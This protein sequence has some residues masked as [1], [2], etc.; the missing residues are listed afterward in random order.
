ML[1]QDRHIWSGVALHLCGV[2]WHLLTGCLHLVGQEGHSAGDKDSSAE[3]Y[4]LALTG[5]IS[6][7]TLFYRLS[8]TQADAS[9][10]MAQSE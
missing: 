6:L 8:D 10:R 5:R 7:L 4:M 1:V 9:L 2:Q 3:K